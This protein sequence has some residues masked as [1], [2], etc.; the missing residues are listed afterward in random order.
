LNPILSCHIVPIKSDW[1]VLVVVH[2][3]VCCSALFSS[4]L[5][6]SRLFSFVLVCSRLFCSVLFSSLLFCVLRL[7][8]L[9]KHWITIWFDL[10]WLSWMSWMRLDSTGNASNWLEQFGLNFTLLYFTL[11][12]F[13]LLYL[14]WFDLIDR[15]EM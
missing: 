2:S 1:F 8:I 12:C 5:V 14:I 4:V 7:S 6:C 15:N 11:L 3:V 10:L 13:T 9:I